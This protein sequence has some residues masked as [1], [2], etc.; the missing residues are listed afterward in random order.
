MAYIRKYGRLPGL[1]VPDVGEVVIASRSTSGPWARAVVTSVY[2]CKGG[3]RVRIGFQW[4]EN[5]EPTRY[6]DGYRAGEKGNV[7]VSVDPAEPCLIRRLVKRPGA[8]TPSR[9]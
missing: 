6:T 9:P 3:E 2:R 4:L 7:Y 8:G 1:Y 5:T